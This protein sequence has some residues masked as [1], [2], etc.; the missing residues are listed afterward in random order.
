MCTIMRFPQRKFFIPLLVLFLGAT[1]LHRAGSLPAAST[2][3]DNENHYRS[4]HDITL[5]PHRLRPHSMFQ[6]S[7]ETLGEYED[8]REYTEEPNLSLDITETVAL[9][10]TTSPT[11]EEAEK[12]TRP[13]TKGTS[14]APVFHKGTTKARNS[15]RSTS[16]SSTVSDDV[17]QRMIAKR[18]GRIPQPTEFELCNT[19]FCAAEGKKLAVSFSRC[20]H[21][22]TNFYGYVCTKGWDFANEDHDYT[23]SDSV[24]SRTIE[25]RLK[26]VLDNPVKETPAPLVSLWNACKHPTKPPSV[27]DMQKIMA[28][29]GYDPLRTPVIPDSV[30]QTAADVMNKI[31]IAPLVFIQVNKDPRNNSKWMIVLDEPTVLVR[32]DDAV[33]KESQ[34]HEM[35]SRLACVYVSLTCG[36]PSNTDTCF[37]LAS[38][39]IEMAKESTLHVHRR[40]T[41]F[42]I[43]PYSKLGYLHHFIA[44]V[45]G[46]THPLDAKK[47]ELLVKSP[48]FVK[49]H[50]ER[51]LL[52]KANAL[53]KYMGFHIMVHLAPFLGIDELLPT[54]LFALSG[55]MWRNP[56]KWRVCL[57]LL[58]HVLP[59]LVTKAYEAPFQNA[60]GFDELTG[61]MLADQIHSVFMEMLP[62]DWL[63]DTSTRKRIAAAVPPEHNRLEYFLDMCQYTAGYWKTPGYLN[64]YHHR[65]SRSVFDTRCEYVLSDNAVIVPIG[66]FNT[67]VPTS[68][69]EKM[70]HLPMIA[71]R[72]AKCLF[73]AAFQSLAFSN[74]E[75]LKWTRRSE[76]LYR[77]KLICFSKQ[78]KHVHNEISQLYSSAE[79]NAALALA[80]EV[81]EDHLFA[82]RYFDLDYRLEGLANVTSRQLFFILYARSLCEVIPPGTTARAD[83]ENRVNIPLKNHPEF[84]D[85]FNCPLD[86]EM[87][88][89]H[90][91][92]LWE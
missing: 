92:R 61:S 28:S 24:L 77:Q 41:K 65:W 43:V 18:H 62:N 63:V 82:N 20:C 10:V 7:Q 36:H 12:S 3:P 68:T 74:P 49:S 81:Y 27:S 46:T 86:S 64:F 25:L 23:D 15:K 1:Q 85:A 58:N 70:F 56:P 32:A 13:S 72:I 53:Y 16:R 50:L 88:P 17:T 31:N 21:P 57:H 29:V 79:D 33:A 75:K 5:Y 45:M 48:H 87:N 59:V 14:G 60:T 26:A 6:L 4:S 66:L 71:P 67:S 51:L 83:R 91:C 76:K 44:T 80:F 42:Q 37:E 34:I 40:G 84:A 30:L 90:K 54:S 8:A 22:C 2:A 19:T 11:T 78:Y 38:I 89:T 52:T 39:I 73:E 69:K 9:T 47:T 35:L 55:K